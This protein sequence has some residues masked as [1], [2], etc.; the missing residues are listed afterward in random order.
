ML[1]QYLPCVAL[2]A[3][4]TPLIYAAM[5]LGSRG[6]PGNSLVFNCRLLLCHLVCA[7]RWVNHT[8]RVVLCSTRLWWRHCL[9]HHANMFKTGLSSYRNLSREISGTSTCRQCSWAISTDDIP[10]PQSWIILNISAPNTFHQSFD[11]N[12]ILGAW[13]QWVRTTGDHRGRPF[14]RPCA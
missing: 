7:Q 11:C 6:D 14:Q 10:F 1:G 8:V 13:D 3:P 12:L 4:C 2:H 5:A 9:G